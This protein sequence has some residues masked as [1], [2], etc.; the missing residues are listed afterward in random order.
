MHHPTYAA[1][2]SFLAMAI[3]AAPA[4]IAPRQVVLGQ[5]TTYDSTH[6]TSVIAH[7]VVSPRVC[8]GL[9]DANSINATFNDAQGTEFRL[10][11]DSEC[12]DFAAVLP[13]DTCVNT[14][15]YFSLSLDCI[16]VADCVNYTNIH[17]PTSQPQPQSHKALPFPF[18]HPPSPQTPHRKSP[19]RHPSAP[20]GHRPRA[21]KHPTNKPKTHRR[22]R[23][24]PS[25]LL[26]FPISLYIPLH[27]NPPPPNQGASPREILIEACRRDNLPLLHEL[28]ASHPTAAQT[29]ALINGARD[30]VGNYCLHIAASSGSYDVLEELL[31]HEGVEVDPLDRL[32]ADSPLH[33]AVRYV[34]ALRAEEWAGAAPLVEL[35]VEAGA[36]VRLRNRAKLR[37]VE[38]VDP[39]NVA[40]RAVL[41]RA[42]YAAM[43]GT[44][45]VDEDAEEEE[46]GSTGS[47]SDSE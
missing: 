37:P 2:A 10:F 26:P 34:N 27:L 45:V 5:Y 30:G 7:D 20:N 39:R 25:L 43:A 6:C 9:P 14:E 3:C 46:G 19:S 1:L 40:L 47:A 32:E 23:G 13:L 22:H 12:T 41:Q 35:L 36:D 11:Y 29:A 15:E 42:E 8:K 31:D 38:L 16:G 33:K 17:S 44:D 18:A 21:S 28:L 24:K 4:P